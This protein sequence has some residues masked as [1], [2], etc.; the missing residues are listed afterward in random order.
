MRPMAVRPMATPTSTRRRVGSATAARAG[1]SGWSRRVTKT[2]AEIMKTP[3]QAASIAD[4]GR[5]GVVGLGARPREPDRVRVAPKVRHAL[6][7]VAEV[8]LE[9]A[10]YLC[11][12]VAGRIVGEELDQLAAGHVE[13]ALSALDMMRC[14]RPVLPFRCR[15]ARFRFGPP[16]STGGAA[17]WYPVRASAR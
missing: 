17:R 14:G 7:A 12:E 3:R 10:Q 16:P 1:D 13:R 4:S 11:G 6:R 5:Q 15:L 9:D 2:Q 8:G